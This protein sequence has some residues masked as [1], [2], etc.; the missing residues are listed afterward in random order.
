MAHPKIIVTRLSADA[1][2]D[3]LED[4]DA[5]EILAGARERLIDFYQ[6]MVPGKLLG[7]T[8]L[9]MAMIHKD[10]DR[11]IK[12]HRRLREVDLWLDSNDA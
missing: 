2:P 3:H 6:K 5:A 10:L 8:D 1:V 7:M 4:K 12:K 11:L 9:E